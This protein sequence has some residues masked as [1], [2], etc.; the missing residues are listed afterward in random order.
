[1]A[2]MNQS[3]PD[4]FTEVINMKVKLGLYEA[5]DLSNEQYHGAEGFYSSSQ[6]KTAVECV[7]LF[8]RKYVTGELVQKSIPAFATGTYYHT[9]ILEPELL[10]EECVVFTG[11]VKRGAAWEKFKDENSSKTIIS[12][13]QKAEADNLIQATNACTTAQELLKSG[14]PELSLFTKLA[15]FPVKVR[16]DWIDL[17]RGFIMDLKSTTGNAKSEKAIIKKVAS[18][19]YDLSAALYL[20]AFNSYLKSQDMP[21]LSKF[22]W[23]FASKDEAN[24]KTYLASPKMIEL[25]RRKY[26]FGLRKLEEAMANGWSFPD[27]V[28]TVSPEPWELQSWEGEEPKDEK[29][30]SKTKPVR[31]SDDSDLL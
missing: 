5:K 15:G 17:D 12:L 3:L 9:A 14:V 8:Y 28:A 30:F 19:D 20:D 4:Y 31:Q 27:T 1:M 26:M 7:E 22:Y 13:S 25:G 23:V 18:Y 21:L 11:K 24:C 29:K 6:F 16:A 10:E 2:A